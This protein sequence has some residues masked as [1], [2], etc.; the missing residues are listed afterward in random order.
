[1]R[2]NNGVNERDPVSIINDIMYQN[3]MNSDI[4][5]GIFNMENIAGNYIIIKN[6]E[7]VF[8]LFAHLKLNS[9]LVKENEHVTTRQKI[10]LIGHSGN[11][12]AP[13]LH[14]QLTDSSDYNLAKGI[15]CCFK[16]LEYM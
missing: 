5:N 11:S 3:R 8:G 13:H 2:I 4:R 10:G 12:M 14:F 7:N 9:I 16:S 1:V 6:T 15:P